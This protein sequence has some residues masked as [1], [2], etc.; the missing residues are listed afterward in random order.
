MRAAC[1][2]ELIHCY[3]LVHDDLPC[4]DDDDL[5]RGKPTCHVV[6][7]E[8]MATLA[9]DS[10]HTLA[11]EILSDG[12]P[13][14]AELVLS[15]TRRLA[16]AAGHQGMVGGQVADLESEGKD[17]DA[18]TLEFIHRR[19]TGALYIASVTMG[20]VA[21]GNREIVS[22]LESFGAHMGLMFQIVDDIMDV[23]G[24]TA[25]IGKRVGSDVDKKKA[26]YPR[27]H[28]MEAA[29]AEARRLTEAAHADL[30]AFGDADARLAQITDYILSRAFSRTE[31]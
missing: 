8:A 7:G 30:E 4:M 10:L 6:F 28:G 26:T 15:L 12:P 25:V 21:S 24:D 29:K 13:A 27:I 17:I 18:E 31:A 14:E 3:S 20:G 2:L 1:A 19:K 23:E 22:T 5:R 16:T 11:Y 9:G